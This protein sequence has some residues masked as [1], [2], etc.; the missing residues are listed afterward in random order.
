MNRQ[1][2]QAAAVAKVAKLTGCTEDQ[3]RRELIAEEWNEADAMLNLRAWM[4]EGAK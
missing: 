2:R 4:K 3:A 1:Q